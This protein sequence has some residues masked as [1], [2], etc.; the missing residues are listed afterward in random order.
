MER[1][2]LA[3]MPD[4]IV[5]YIESLEAELEKVRRYESGRAAPDVSARSSEPP[6]TVQVITIS[7]D[8]RAKRTP[9]HL[10]E[11]QRRGGMGVFDLETAEDD[12][13]VVLVL[14]DE[15]EKLLLFTNQGRVF[16]VAVEAILQAEVRARGMQLGEA[17]PLRP[18]E[19]IVSGLPAE[20]GVYVALLSQRGWIRRVRS[21]FFGRSL[22]PGMVFHDV[23][24]GGP[25]TAACWTRGSGDLF[26]ATTAGQAIRFMETQVPDRRG[27]LGIRLTPGDT[28][29]AV[30]PVTEESGVFLLSADGRG[31]VRLM[32]GFRANKAPGAGGKQAIKTD[33]LTGAV[34]VSPTDE[35]FVI[36]QLS[37]IIRF[38]AEEVPAKEGVVQGV[39]CMNLRNDEAVAVAVNE[40]SGM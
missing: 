1:P 9:R 14:A 3:H 15:S 35:L 19:Q 22:I 16:R 40:A 7:R 37:K 5:A 2:D 23:N 25:L 13:P 8:G 18:G 33:K 4:E 31:T 30:A 27:C 11:A 17:L 34:A 28:A 29:I 10:Y 6:T 36:S 39:N 26:I 38:S 24:E 12:Q 20:G 21:S 32:S